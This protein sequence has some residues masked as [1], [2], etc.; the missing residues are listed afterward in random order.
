MQ[1]SGC[2]MT[3]SWVGGGLQAVVK[4]QEQKQLELLGL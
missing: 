4:G 3:D 1:I 2:D